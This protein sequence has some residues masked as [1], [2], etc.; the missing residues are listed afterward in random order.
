VLVLERISPALDRCTPQYALV[1]NPQRQHVLSVL[2][3]FVPGHEC[4]QGAARDQAAETK[5]QVLHGSRE[6]DAALLH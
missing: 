4:G 5:R 1:V 6:I 2:A 3:V